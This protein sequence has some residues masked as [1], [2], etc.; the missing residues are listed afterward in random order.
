MNTLSNRE[1]TR[2]ILLC[3]CLCTLLM[4][5]S[6]IPVR[7]QDRGNPSWYVRV[8]P[9][10]WL[11][12]IDGAETLGEEPGERI[13]GDFYV[14]VEDTVL[15]AN[16]ALRCEVGRGR[17]RGILNLSNARM[18]NPTVATRT[19]D[20]TVTAPADHDFNWFTGELFIATQVG[21][22]TQ[23]HGIEVY[24]G[25]RYVRQKQDLT[26]SGASN[27]TQNIKETWFE[28]VIGSR[29]YSKLGDRF[30]AMFHSDLGGF[31]VGSNFTWTMGGELGFEL[32][33]Y[34]DITMRY[35]YQE[36]EYDNEKEGVDRYIWDNGVQQ[37]WY[38][39]LVFK[40]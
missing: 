4:I 32:S 9:Y 29:I 12:S 5:F 30:W 28:P 39:G 14:P 25:G 34:A 33:K 11:S 21:S 2:F 3:C 26:V 27:G 6:G 22:F 15:E 18:Q 31:G 36:V 37:G 8:V 20:T 17:V 19:S 7:A 10:L 24:A 13:V 35:N 38:F 23:S 40:F 16:W 1:Q